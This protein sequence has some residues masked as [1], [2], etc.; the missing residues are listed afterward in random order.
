MR[1]ELMIRKAIKDR[2]DSYEGKTW[3]KLIMEFK[4]I[5]DFPDV[6]TLRQTLNES[7]KELF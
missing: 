1:N 7:Q 3:S 6:K 2:F 4:G 5:E